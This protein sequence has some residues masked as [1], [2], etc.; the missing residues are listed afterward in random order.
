MNKKI[1]VFV[2]GQTEL[3]FVREYLLRQ[4]NYAVEIQCRTLFSDGKFSSAEYDFQCPNASLLFQIIN[5][6]NDNAVISRMLKREEHLWETGF[7]SIIC[8]RD[9]YCRAYREEST[10]I[11][12][13]LNKKFINGANET[14]K[15]AKRPEQIDFVFAIMEVEA[16]FLGLPTIFTSMNPTL[17]CE[18]IN[19]ELGVNLSVID[20]ESAVFHPADLVRRIYALVGSNYS[21]HK[22]DIE[23]I[24]AFLTVQNIEVLCLSQKCSSL[25]TFLD[26]IQKRS[27]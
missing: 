19:Q 22:S 7:S 8:L 6:G 2:E 21:K 16:W 10:T 13:E 23:A 5:V 3:I 9:M 14:L 4:F 15:H 26:C 25:G 11:S 18:Y 12:Q 1:A 17:T 27:A 20:P 24:A